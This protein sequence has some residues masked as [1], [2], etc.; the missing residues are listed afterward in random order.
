MHKAVRW[1]LVAPAAVGAATL[2]FVALTLVWNLVRAVNIVPQDGLIDLALASAGINGVAAAAGVIA[3]ARVAPRAPQWTA[4]V[5]AGVFVLIAILLLLLTNVI[6]PHLHISFGWHV[7]S[8][9]AWIAGA[10]Y[11]AY[12]FSNTK[13][14][15]RAAADAPRM[16]ARID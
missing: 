10:V 11:A 13:Y 12:S 9:L 5:V 8:S 1:I 4:I 6:R 2:A 14:R 7:F 15:R 3:G 16:P